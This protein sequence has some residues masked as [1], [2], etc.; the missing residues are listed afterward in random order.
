MSLDY[1]YVALGVAALA[2]VYAAGLWAY[3]RRQSKGSAK[4]VEISDAVRQGAA[5]FLGREY[6]V[7]APIAVVI[8]LLIFGLI[9]IPQGT[10][11]ATAVG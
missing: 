1:G 11:G 9:D 2:L 5:A 8:T 10:G 4:M 6:K 3:I 7:V